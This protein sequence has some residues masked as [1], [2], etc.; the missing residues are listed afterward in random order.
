MWGSRPSS[1]ASHGRGA[2]SSRRSRARRATSSPS[3]SNGG[4]AFRADRHRRHV[5][6][7][8]GS[9]ARARARTRT[10]RDRRRRSPCARVGWT[11]RPGARRRG[12]RQGDSRAGK[13]AL[14]AINKTD[15]RRARNR[16][17]SSST[18]SGSIR[19]SRSRPSMGMASAICSMRSSSDCLAPGRH[20]RRRRASEV[21]D[22]RSW[23]G[24]MP[25]SLRWSIGCSA[26]SE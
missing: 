13:P 26:K 5:R 21:C 12:N 6:R 4:R 24:R 17:R 15:D 8:R 23:D 20:H 22:R 3:Q 1:T 19:C 16:C 10:P 2:R 7:E 18:S 25:A 14:L 11:R 9:A